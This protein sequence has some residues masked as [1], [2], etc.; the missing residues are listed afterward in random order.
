MVRKPFPECV[1]DEMKEEE[2][3]LGFALMMMDFLILEGSIE[4]LE[5]KA[6]T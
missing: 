1:I 2:S 6:R 4:I 5:V 3:K